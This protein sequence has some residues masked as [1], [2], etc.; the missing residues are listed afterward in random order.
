MEGSGRSL[1][2]S[3]PRAP[4]VCVGQPLPMCTTMGPTDCPAPATGRS[5]PQWNRWAALSRHGGLLDARTRVLSLN[6]NKR[7]WGWTGPREN[8]PRVPSKPSP[9]RRPPS[10]SQGGPAP[11][12]PHPGGLCHLPPT[13][14]RGHP[15]PAALPPPPRR[16]GRR[17]RGG[18][19]QLRGAAEGR[20]GPGGGS[21]PSGSILPSLTHGHTHTHPHARKGAH[22]Q[23][24][25][26]GQLTPGSQWWRALGRQRAPAGTA[27][28]GGSRPGGGERRGG[29]SGACARA[30][31]R[32]RVCARAA[33][34]GSGGRAAEPPHA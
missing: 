5:P 16:R 33:V 28:G 22:T 8:S 25:T 17:A 30:R 10:S 4:P 19:A 12:H 3:H 32:L 1:E 34:G 7:G 6:N 29:G 26:R 13:S 2:R 9:I 14:E 27:R 24:I 15:L 23:E 20:G 18:G 31:V 21:G 11:P